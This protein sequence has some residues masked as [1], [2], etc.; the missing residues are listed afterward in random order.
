MLP[1]RTSLP[2]AAR[3]AATARLLSSR[4][5]D[6]HFVHFGFL[7]S[8][9]QSCKKGIKWENIGY[10]WSVEDIFMSI[11]V[12]YGSPTLN[13][14]DGDAYLGFRNWPHVNVLHS[15]TEQTGIFFCF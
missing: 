6:F 5:W 11:E 2:S 8:D 14:G 15:L 12:I 9:H 4:F 3:D 1:R 7:T 13:L 10:T